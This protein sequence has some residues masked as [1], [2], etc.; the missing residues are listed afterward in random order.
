MAQAVIEHPFIFDVDVS[1]IYHTLFILA[2]DAGDCERLSMW[3]F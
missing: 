1:V 2:A 3:L